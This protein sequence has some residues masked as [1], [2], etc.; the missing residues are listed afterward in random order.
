MPR[1]AAPADAAPPEPRLG[2]LLARLEEIRREL[3]RDDVE[4]EDQLS[5]YR[6]GCAHVLAAK[7]ILNSVRSEVEVLMTDTDAAPL[8]GAEE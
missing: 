5:L 8:R 3:D 6:E 4:L 7:R 2:E 1:T